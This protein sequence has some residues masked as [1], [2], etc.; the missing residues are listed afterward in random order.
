MGVEV[1]IDEFVFQADVCNNTKSLTFPVMFKKGKRTIDG[2]TTTVNVNIVGTGAGVSCHLD[3]GLK[4]YTSYHDNG[5]Q[6]YKKNVELTGVYGKSR[7]SIT[8]VFS[9]IELGGSQLI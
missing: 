6:K 5:V 7:I 4:R 8:R 9:C 3:A 1:K 2:D